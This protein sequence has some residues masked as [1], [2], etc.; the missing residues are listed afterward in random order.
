M[1]PFVKFSIGAAAL[2]G[3]AFGAWDYASPLWAA[4]SLQTAI[5][6]RDA[7]ALNGRVD[8]E[9]L[10]IN[11]KA[12]FAARLAANNL[13]APNST[14]EYAA[15]RLQSVAAMIDA[16]I[17]PQAIRLA[18]DKAAQMPPDSGVKKSF[19][20]ASIHR[21]SFNQFHASLDPADTMAIR[22]E[23]K[24]LGWQVTDLKLPYDLKAAFAHTPTVSQIERPE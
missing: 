3:V 16:M 9:A 8:F 18:M 10:R 13:G 6:D 11:L 20:L 19:N 1:R 12:Q 23:R 24:R 2:S 17:S 7:T 5:L 4:Q 21:D 14:P 22:F 15:T